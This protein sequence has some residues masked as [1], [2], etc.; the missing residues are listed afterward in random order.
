MDATCVELG[1]EKIVRRSRHACI[2]TGGEIAAAATIIP[3]PLVHFGLMASGDTVMRSGQDR[4]DLSRSDSIIAL[5][6]ET[7]GVWDVLP[8]VGIK[9]VCDY[10]DSHKNKLWQGYAAA[11]AA[12]CTKAFL[13]EWPMH[14][15]V[16]NQPTGPVPSLC[17]NGPAFAVPFERD[18][19]F[20]GRV[21][22]MDALDSDEP[23]TALQ[24]IGGIG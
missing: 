8:C 18:V 5:E 6:M 10:S 12:A 16:P 13:K 14:L 15:L 20:V 2:V 3:S 4:D 24:G 22:V 1:C 9:G 7:V 21:D 11:N 23:R 19:N 17:H